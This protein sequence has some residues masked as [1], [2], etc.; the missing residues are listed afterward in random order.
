MTVLKANPLQSL[1]NLAHP[2]PSDPCALLLWYSCLNH[3]V[4]PQELGRAQER[5]KTPSLGICP[6]AL[7]SSIP[8]AREQELGSVSHSTIGN[9]FLVANL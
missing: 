1:C 3:K 8:G 6:V 7:H 9:T 4:N 5:S 2:R